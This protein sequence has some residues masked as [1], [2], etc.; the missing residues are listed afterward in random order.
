MQTPRCG[1]S[2]HCSASVLLPSL[3]S[4]TPA[5]L[6]TSAVWTSTSGAR[7]DSSKVFS[8]VRV[9]VSAGPLLLRMMVRGT[10]LARHGRLIW[11]RGHRREACGVVCGGG[12]HAR[13]IYGAGGCVVA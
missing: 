12:G 1:A 13:T 3:E 10:R 7:R 6:F 8:H 11:R 5:C 9:G 2:T 4:F